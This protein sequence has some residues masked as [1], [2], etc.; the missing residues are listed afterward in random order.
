MRTAGARAGIWRAAGRGGR[1]RGAPG[2]PQ[3]G[4]PFTR[5]GDHVVEQLDWEVRVRVLAHCRRRYR[6]ACRCPV[7]AAVTAPGPPKAIGKGLL[8]NGFIALLLTERYVAGRSQNSLVT[9]LARHGAD[10]SPT[11]VTG[12][13]AVA[14]T[15]LAPLEE[16]IT[17]KSRDSWHL[18]AD[19]TSWHVFSPDEGDGPAKWWLWVFIGPDT[20]CFVMDP[21]RAR[22]VLARHAGIDEETGQLAD[23]GDGP[24]RLVISRTPQIRA[25]PKDFTLSLPGRRTSLARLLLPGSSGP[26][27]MSAYIRISAYMPSVSRMPGSGLLRKPHWTLVL[28]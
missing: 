1:G 27:A 10:I 5:L 12:T 7:P 14:G 23:D 11:T 3:C 28:W 8:S 20:T 26:P 19:E 2:C 21:T 18:H 15:L 22:A 6:R 17:A 13:C 4:V 9:G 25:S 16:A 24:R